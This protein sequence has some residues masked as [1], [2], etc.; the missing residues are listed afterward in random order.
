M[1]NSIL[2][3]VLCLFAGVGA[4]TSGCNFSQKLP[5]LDSSKPN[6]IL[7]VAD[8]LGYDFLG[9]YGDSLANTPTLDRM[10]KEGIKLNAFYA[11]SAVCSPSRAA[12]LTGLFP[13]KTGVETVVKPGR[14]G[15]NPEVITLAEKLKTY[16]YQT[17][18]VGKW[19]LGYQKEEHPL[20]QGFDHFVGSLSGHAD[21]ISHVRNDG[22]H[23]LWQNEKA[24]HQTGHLTKVFTDH[25]IRF[26]EDQKHP[27]FLYLPY[28][29]PHTPYL[30]PGYPAQFD[31]RGGARSKGFRRGEIESYR[32]LISLMDKHIGRILQTLTDKHLIDNTII[33]FVSDNGEPISIHQNYA[34]SFRGAKGLLLESGIRVPAILYWKNHFQPRVVHEPIMGA[35][36]FPTLIEIVDTLPLQL[37]VD[38]HSVLSFFTDS[39]IQPVNRKL[40]WKLLEASAVRAGKWKAIRVSP[41]S[42]SK[43]RFNLYFNTQYDVLPTDSIAHMGEKVFLYDVEK[44][45]QEAQDVSKKYPEVVSELKKEMESQVP[46]L[47]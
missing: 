41:T 18:I 32:N 9:C 30:M 21:Y 23:D 39:L 26:I 4:M 19:H 6:I 44:D 13:S 36:I 35:D 29:A 47:H 31:A 7:I 15:M 28:Q 34:A 27:F 38:G 17:G 42:L 37:Q 3:A 46:K 40:F 20:N 2:Y 22:I 33:W 24:Y 25:A 16:G 11:N 10:A 12:I 1:K 14:K 8:D 5:G 43:N 45:P